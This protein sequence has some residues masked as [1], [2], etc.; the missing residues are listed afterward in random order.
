MLNIS[1]LQ[2]LGWALQLCLVQL[3]ELP[4]SRMPTKQAEPEAAFQKRLIL[5]SIIFATFWTLLLAFCFSKWVEIERRFTA[6]S[7]EIEG[8]VFI[9]VST[10]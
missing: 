10:K 9:V 6:V 3:L 5:R 1:Y 4:K 7:R 8:V 2:I